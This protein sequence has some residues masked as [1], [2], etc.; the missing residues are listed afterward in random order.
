ME[1]KTTKE[2]IS[3]AMKTISVIVPGSTAN[4]DTIYNY[5]HLRGSEGRITM[6]A[7]NHTGGVTTITDFDAE[8]EGEFSRLL[9]IKKTT[10]L[11]SLMGDEIE[12]RDDANRILIKSGS[13]RHRLATEKPT[14]FPLPT[15]QQHVDF[16]VSATVFKEILNYVDCAASK[17]DAGQWTLK[18]I[19]LQVKEGIMRVYTCDGHQTARAIY[20]LPTPGKE[21]EALIPILNLNAIMKMLPFK[22][23]DTIKITKNGNNVELISKRGTLIVRTMDGTFPDVDRLIPP[24]L[25]HH[26]AVEKEELSQAIRRVLL[27]SAKNKILLTAMSHFLIVESTAT[28]DGDSREMLPVVCETLGADA[29]C[30]FGVLGNHINGALAEFP[31]TTPDDD[32][33]SHHPTEVYLDFGGPRNQ[34]M[35]TAKEKLKFD[36]VYI[37]SVSRSEEV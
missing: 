9:P 37:A 23:D 11:I 17:V 16:E 26:V 18:C 27:F 4:V 24:R 10:Q 6:T 28:A 22:A 8:F 5:V 3:E 31:N 2:S 30:D 20:E 1:F 34:F 35:I 33:K 15:L 19:K 13:S 14:N 25:D 29:Q 21:F 7:I 32:G 12:V 36:F